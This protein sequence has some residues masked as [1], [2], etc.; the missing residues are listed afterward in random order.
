[1]SPLDMAQTDAGLRAPGAFDWSAD[2]R[3]GPI[4]KTTADEHLARPFQPLRQLLLI[5]DAPVMV[6]Q[7][8]RARAGVAPPANEPFRQKVNSR[9][10]VVPHIRFAR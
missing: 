7:S 4:L 6:R 2:H 1:M 5:G 10:T 3:L 9:F 8:K